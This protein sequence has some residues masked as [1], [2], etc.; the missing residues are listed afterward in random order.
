MTVYTM[1]K[2]TKEEPT[3]ILLGSTTV[4]SRV[5]VEFTDS[6]GGDRL[7]G[8]V[9]VKGCGSDSTKAIDL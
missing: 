5:V 2:S 7:E 8:K 1:L 6:P 9:A 3:T 4:S